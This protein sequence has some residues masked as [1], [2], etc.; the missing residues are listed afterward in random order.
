M[1]QLACHYPCAA[2]VP[3]PS[4]RTAT[5]AAPSGAVLLPTPR[6]LTTRSSDKLLRW[7]MPPKHRP[8]PPVPGSM[9][10]LTRTL[11]LPVLLFWM[12]VMAASYV[13]WLLK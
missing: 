5:T 1:P 4:S 8:T 10:F 3:S 7:P 11:W 2:R 6:N 12:L 13:V 9:E